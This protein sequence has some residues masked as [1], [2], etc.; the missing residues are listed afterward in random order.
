[1]PSK[2]LQRRRALAL[3][4]AALCGLR[5]AQAAP[6]LR[7]LSVE[8]RVSE[9]SLAAQRGA[10]GAVSI[11]SRGGQAGVRGSVVVQAGSARQALEAT[12]RVLVLNGGRA[13]LRVAQGMPVEDTEIWWTPWG[14]GAAVRS[15][16]VEL[17][18]GFEVRPLWPGGAAPVTLEVSAQRSAPGPAASPRVQ[19]SRDAL[20]PQWTL[21]TT[22]LAP[23]DAWVTVAELHGRQAASVVS[24][25]F[26]AATASRQ[27]ELQLRVSLP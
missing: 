24:G 27:R 4:G 20:P 19:G 1:M 26:G 22:V 16:W 15:Q 7:N 13:T 9:E 18:N 14:P 8:M 23:L 17:S 11:G 21:M 3:A 25:G 12:Q 2:L 5:A 6:P 10:Q